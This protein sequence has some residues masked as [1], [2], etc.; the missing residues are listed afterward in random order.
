MYDSNVIHL[1]LL[2]SISL[3]PA[4]TINKPTYI[5]TLITI[6]YLIYYCCIRLRGSLRNTH[7]HTHTQRD[8]LCSLCIFILRRAV[9]SLAL[10]KLHTYVPLY[11][12]P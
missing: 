9:D 6:N 5:L 1:L 8:A 10:F 7:T 12:Q 4:I 2:L 3:S 11:Y